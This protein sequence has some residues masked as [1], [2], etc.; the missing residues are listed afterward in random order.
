MQQ[1]FLKQKKHD[2]TSTADTEMPP[3][4]IK[5]LQDV[6]PLERTVNPEM[7][8]K[9]VREHEEELNELMQKSQAA[10]R[11]QTSMPLVQGITG[12]DSF[13]ST[14]TTSFSTDTP[15]AEDED[16]L[17]MTDLEIY[18]LLKR[19][20]TSKDDVEKL[21]NDIYQEQIRERSDTSTLVDDDERRAHLELTRSTL[22]HIDIPLIYKDTDDS[23]VGAWPDQ[24]LDMERQKLRPMDETQVKL[25]VADLVDTANDERQSSKSK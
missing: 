3:E 14:K 23:Y 4:L 2:S 15:L 13:T 6:G 21:V 7:T 17:G 8:S 25:V 19:Q 10:Q 24:V 9:R 22:Q 12:D 18:K 5:F 16:D 11:K 20:Q 1:E